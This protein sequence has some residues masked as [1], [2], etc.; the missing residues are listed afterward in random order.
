MATKTFS[1]CALLFFVHHA[2]PLLHAQYQRASRNRK[3]LSLKQWGLL[4]YHHNHQD[5]TMHYHIT[6]VLFG[7]FIAMPSA[8]SYYSNNPLSNPEIYEEKSLATLK[9]LL[10]EKKHDVNKKTMRGGISIASCNFGKK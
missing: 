10:A 5:T 8:A 9:S 6:L 2:L 3:N 7:F 4:H 1:A